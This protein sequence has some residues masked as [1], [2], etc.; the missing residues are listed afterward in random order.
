MYKIYINHSLLILAKSQK[1]EKAIE[2]YA[3]D[4][5]SPY[6]GKK[7]ILLNFL[8]KLEKN[9][10]SITIVLYSA[11]FK[12]LKA[13]FISLFKIVKASGGIVKNE[14]SEVLFIHRRGYWDL[15]KGKLEI[16]EGKKEAAIREVEEETGIQDVTIVC[17]LGKTDHFFRNKSNKR[18]IK[19]S[20]WYEMYSPKQPLIPQAEEDI[21]KAIWT[22]P[23]V[24]LETQDPL[25]PS[26]RAITEVYLRNV[27]V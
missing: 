23:S 13:D 15:P 24:M 9:P 19:R 25:Y 5:V 26:I 12:I 10:D 17:K 3:P 1:K 6:L 27:T 7:K 20:Y 2:K 4:L 11:S 16:G 14:K 18:C 8:D 22:R 21:D